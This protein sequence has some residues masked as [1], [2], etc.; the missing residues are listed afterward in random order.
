MRLPRQRCTT[1]VVR[2]RSPYRA[3]RFCTRVARR[4]RR[5]QLEAAQAAAEGATAGAAAAPG[6]AA[7][8]G[9][10]PLDPA[11][12]RRANLRA[13]LDRKLPK[14]ARRA[15]AVEEEE[16]EE[17]EEAPDDEAAGAGLTSRQRPSR[18]TA[19]AAGHSD[20]G[21]DGYSRRIAGLQ[22]LSEDNSED[23]FV[24]GDHL[25]EDLVSDA[26]QERTRVH[27]DKKSE[28]VR[29]R[30]AACE[31]AA[32]AT[33]RRE[34][35]EQRA[36]ALGGAAL[37]A[38]SPAAESPAED[39]PAE[40]SP[41]RELRAG[42]MSEPPRPAAV[43]ADAAGGMQRM[44]RG[45]SHVR[46]AAAADPALMVDLA[47]GGAVVN[48]CLLS[49]RLPAAQA[50]PLHRARVLDEDMPAA[51]MPRIPFAAGLAPVH[52]GQL[53]QHQRS[54]KQHRHRDA[55][56]AG[57][58]GASRKRR[59]SHGPHVRH[60]RSGQAAVGADGSDAGE[61]SDSGSD[62]E[63]PSGT[64]RRT[65][66][67]GAV[68]L[69]RI[70]LGH[71]RAAP[72][73]RLRN[74]DGGPSRAQGF[75]GD[76][77][78]CS[79]DS[80][81]AVLAL[82][83]SIVPPHHP[84]YPEN[85]PPHHGSRAAAPLCRVAAPA[86]AD[87][88]DEQQHVAPPVSRRASAFAS[89]LA[90]ARAVQWSDLNEGQCV[91]TASADFVSKLAGFRRVKVTVEDEDDDDY[92]TA[93]VVVAGSTAGG[94]SSLRT[95]SDVE[96]AVEILLLLAR[97][98][99]AARL[100]EI[101][102]RRIAL[103]ADAHALIDFGGSCLAA[104][105]HVISG[106]TLLLRRLLE[107]KQCI[108]VAADGLYDCLRLVANDCSVEWLSRNRTKVE[109]VGESNWLLDS[110]LSGV[111]DTIEQHFQRLDSQSLAAAVP[112]LLRR[113][114]ITELLADTDGKYGLELRN[115][116]L[117]L[118]HVAASKMPPEP[119]ASSDAADSEEHLDAL[120]DW[121]Q[122]V[123]PAAEL[124]KA[125]LPSI[126]A[127]LKLD[128]NARGVYVPAGM[129]APPLPR[130]SAFGS[131]CEGLERIFGEVLGTARRLKAGLSWWDVERHVL[132]T[133]ASASFWHRHGPGVRLPAVRIWAA[134][135]RVAPQHVTSRDECGMLLRAWI[136]SMADSEQACRGPAR[137]AARHLTVALLSCP[138]AEALFGNVSQWRESF[139]KARDDH[140]AWLKDS[141]DAVKTVVVRAAAAPVASALRA[142]VPSW[143][144][145]LIDASKPRC[146][147]LGR[148]VCLLLLT[149]FRLH[150]SQLGRR[151]KLST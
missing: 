47:G 89:L 2:A 52:A 17:E 7:A 3:H 55:A 33:R 111:A 6:N 101:V 114:L 85:A 144:L 30:Q 46:R 151:P 83:P 58:P 60:R 22:Q 82:N 35:R 75:G 50:A 119:A 92:A 81:P 135:I 14:T 28:A 56:L 45:P 18:R 79:D 24:V 48:N 130:A 125:V 68:G 98:M 147:P 66:P 53:K 78:G 29:S 104:R 26:S 64:R 74:A 20:A 34:Q 43:P 148:V 133:D 51:A 63:S 93:A 37:A 94:A 15:V 96:D 88:E 149:R 95:P 140:A 59:S 65:A 127:L 36:H 62:S 12:R 77:D 117:R 138:L 73:G 4:L 8:R 134:V 143:A 137:T 120:M 71:R 139:L 118:V 54:D 13:L 115:T 123:R 67:A 19:G 21:E 31:R 86:A 38:E 106:T 102:V 110:A 25:G 80:R 109:Q 72:G 100:R 44:Q 87:D 10:A 141:S 70:S 23:S 145:V 84:E 40:D 105:V 146:V 97:H 121:I 99:P 32:L 112:A 107:R 126:S 124:F 132:G 16:S 57:A 136:V 108:T 69:P 27:R 142:S 42:F 90:D 1:R 128:C 76:L 113:E 116:A 5:K 49:E 103:V 11:A 131:G 91:R 41:L 61:D 129:P 39:S 9:S 150:H 122:A